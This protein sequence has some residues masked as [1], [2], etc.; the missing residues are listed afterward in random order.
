MIIKKNNKDIKQGGEEGPIRT[1]QNTVIDDHAGIK[2]PPVTYSV[3]PSF[4]YMAEEHLHV[5]TDKPGWME[6]P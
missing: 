5:L 2:W 1:D 3:G 4:P 6:R